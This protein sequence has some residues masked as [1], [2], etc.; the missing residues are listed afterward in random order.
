MNK[1]KIALLIDL[2]S[3]RI[4]CDGFKKLFAEIEEEYEIA[5]VK[6]YSYVAKRNR[7]FNEYI[8]AKGYDA[9]TPVAS[10]RRNK[11]DSRQIID[12][13]KISLNSTVDAVGFAVGEGDILPILTELKQ[14]G[15][16]VIEIGVEE[17]AYSDAFNG[18]IAV[19]PSYLREGYAAPTKKVVKKA[20][21]KVAAPKETPYTAEVNKIFEGRSILNKYRK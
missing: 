10:R 14:T 5:Y 18:F 3:L 1:P 13:T 21:K 19:N 20:P 12:G 6:F 9:V 16:H 17:G 4:S 11:L 2:G 7:D 8:A 15:K